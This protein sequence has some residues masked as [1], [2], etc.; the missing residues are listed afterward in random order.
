MHSAYREFLRETGALNANIIYELNAS[1]VPAA[2]IFSDQF[3]GT[4][5]SEMY[6]KIPDLLCFKHPIVVG[7]VLP[8]SNQ[9]EFRYFDAEDLA[10]QAGTAWVVQS[11][12]AIPAGGMRQLFA[13]PES[14]VPAAHSTPNCV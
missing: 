12:L 7:L 5:L 3:T 13:Q 11:N 4:Q 1:R 2:A 10:K 14:L 6:S 9:P 8:S